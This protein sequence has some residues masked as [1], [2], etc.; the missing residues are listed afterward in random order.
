MPDLLWAGLALDITLV[1]D[2]VSSICKC[3]HMVGYFADGL[4][5]RSRD[6]A[7]DISNAAHA[8]RALDAALVLE[9]VSEDTFVQHIA[10][11][12]YGPI[13]AVLLPRYDIGPRH[14]DQLSERNSQLTQLLSE[15]GRVQ[16]STS[17]APVKERIDGR[18]GHGPSEA[19]QVRAHIL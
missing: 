5:H 6:A 15:L 4:T 9:R 1:D 8:Q 19:A 18:R 7:P 11:L 3:I 16:V 10:G 17:Y 14:R 12:H 2:G 13:H